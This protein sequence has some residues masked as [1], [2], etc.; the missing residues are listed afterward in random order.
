[1]CLTKKLT[2]LGL[3]F[4]GSF[5]VNVTGLYWVTY[6]KLRF[7]IQN[8]LLKYFLSQKYRYLTVPYEIV[9]VFSFLFLMKK[10][11]N[12]S[13]VQQF[14][15]KLL[16]TSLLYMLAT[17]HHVYVKMKRRWTLIFGT[18]SSA[19]RFSFVV[20]LWSGNLSFRPKPKSFFVMSACHVVNH[21]KSRQYV[22]IKR[23]GKDP[24]L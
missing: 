19:L 3:S 11:F 6:I 20:I 21:V 1:M 10:Y 16:L 7:E 24:C 22:N 15:I 4:N 5:W 18:H 13:I 2:K 14:W 17:V 9:C 8:I 12:I 23:L